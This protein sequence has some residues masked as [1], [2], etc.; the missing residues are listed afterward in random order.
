MDKMSELICVDDEEM[1]T[2]L[3]V[4]LAAGGR[5]VPLLYGKGAVE[6]T[7]ERDRARREFVTWLIARLKSYGYR[8][9]R[10]PQNPSTWPRTPG[11]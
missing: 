9:Y 3:S 8:F 4:I 11:E 6:G 2:D 10:V 1:Q 7:P 5:R